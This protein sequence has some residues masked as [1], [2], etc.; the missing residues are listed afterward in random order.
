MLNGIYFLL[1][2]LSTINDC[3]LHSNEE[4][5]DS[6]RQDL[7]RCGQTSTL[8][9]TCFL[10]KYITRSWLRERISSEQHYWSAMCLLDLFL[11]IVGGR[12]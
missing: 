3:T 9:L 11:P 7:Q 6:L 2:Q 4:I 8:S 1:S 12:E 5:T 10:Y